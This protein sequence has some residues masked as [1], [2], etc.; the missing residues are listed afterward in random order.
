MAHI[1][2][3]V[4]A[5]PVLVTGALVSTVLVALALRR[6]DYER[7]PQAAVLSA[8][9][10]VASLIQVPAG[11]SSVHLLLNGLMGLLLGWTAVP[12]IL[13]ALILQAVFF[14][15][16]GVL[17]LGVNTLNMAVPALV[18]ALALTAPLRE[19]G[20]LAQSERGR[21]PRSSG[22]TSVLGRTPER[23]AFWVG[24]LAGLLGVALTGALVALSLAASGAAF[25]AAAWVI[26]AAYVP[27]ALVE[28]LV[29][30]TVV[31]FLQ[32]VEPGLLPQAETT[33]D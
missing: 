4:L 12:A 13:V 20:R 3:G 17:V 18:C 26:L 19:G 29:T 1:P 33:G 21:L 11:P 32:R 16:G 14:G 6:L 22:L 7:L 24:A 31:A 15:Y 25:Q 27:L 23:R 9:F 28:A 5:A 30:G 8:A 10:F 2:D